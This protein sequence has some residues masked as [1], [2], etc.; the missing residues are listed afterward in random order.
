MAAS[1]VIVIGGGLAGLSAAHTVLE[2]GG[3]VLVLDK[4]PFMG[5]NSVKATSGI[6]GALTK[7]QMKMGIKDSAE[8][9]EAD[10]IKSAA[11]LGGT[12]AP[13]Y[14]A[15]LAHV[16]TH[17]SGP[18]VDWLVDH[19]GLDLSL[20]SRLGGHSQPRTHRGSAKFPGFTIT[21][22]L[23][24]K[25]EEIEEASKGAD[26]RIIN[27]A[28]VSALL[29]DD[30]GAVIGVQY[31]KG[32]QTF[33]EYGP[34]IIATGGF[35]ADFDPRGILAKVRPDLLH[36]PTTNGEHCS[37]DGIKIAIA[38]GAGTVDME[39]V[40][41]HP[42]GLVHPDEPDAKVK[43]L[44]A[45]ALRGVGGIMLDAD[46][47]RFVDE[48]EK[49]DYVT[50]KMNRNKGPFR[51][52]L[53]A[54]GAKE[55]MWHCK[56]YVGRGVMKAYPNAAALAKDM[57]LPPA[58]VARTFADYSA[59]AAKGTPDRFGKKFFQNA[60][61]TPTEELHVAIITPVLHY[62][63]GGLS[64]NAAAEVLTPGGKP[65]AGLYAA[66]EVAGGIHGRNRL[67]GNS[68]LDCVVFGRV[69]GATAARGLLRD[70]MQRARAAP[71]SRIAPAPTAAA[72]TAMTVLSA[73]EVAKHTSEKD[74]WVIL[75][76]KVYDVSE[77][78]PDHPG[79]KKAIMLYAGK[80]AS[81]EFNMLH[82]AN[83]LTKYLPA[84]A[85]LGVLGPKSKM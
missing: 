3:R 73:D 59:A 56:H 39:S 80:D 51:L 8:L 49:R 35:A 17:E 19:F 55:I 81:E 2:A 76:G 36:L 15:P 78:L 65:I 28:T 67:G 60:P 1:Q 5:G 12:E 69:A 82:A 6:N 42:T 77:F 74:C 20:V 4:M 29:R 13:T 26:G 53:N 68:L 84:A 41:V 66:G 22:A 16:L 43:F 79:G 58:T 33:S 7:T 40:Q 45:E 71:T 38:S 14:T 44:A 85:C 30:K 83:V 50:D 34:V 52:V 46:G 57:G 21:Y 32:G 47:Q 61:F 31:T 37:G 23:M 48:L 11:G 24:E 9:F 75:N 18:A 72:A 64:I 70:A 10:T 54:A 62:C 25:L 27:K 63:M